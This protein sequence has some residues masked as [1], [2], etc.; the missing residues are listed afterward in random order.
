MAYDAI[1]VG[2]GYA[3]A[4]S[5]RCLAEDGKTVL[6]LEKRNHIGGNAYDRMDENGV[7]RHVYG[8]H[9]F[10]TNSKQ[11]VDFLSRFTEIGRAHV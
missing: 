7:R 4:V 3:G 10:H 8:P 9:L 2:A 11:A 6:V 5:A 1:I